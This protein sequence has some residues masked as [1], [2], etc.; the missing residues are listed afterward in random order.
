MSRPVH[1]QTKFLTASQVSPTPSNEATTSSP[2]LMIS[3]LLI[4]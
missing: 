4:P 3:L 2:P 1:F